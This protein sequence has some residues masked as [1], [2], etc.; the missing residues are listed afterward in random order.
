MALL[1]VVSSGCMV[2]HSRKTYEMV[3]VKIPPDGS[4]EDDFVVQ[5]FS[6]SYSSN[7]FA[8]DVRAPFR[9]DT[10]YHTKKPYRAYGF[11]RVTIASGSFRQDLVVPADRLRVM[12]H[13]VTS[14][15][16]KG[17]YYAEINLPRKFDYVPADKT[18]ILTLEIQG[19]VERGS[20]RR[21]FVWKERYRYEENRVRAWVTFEDLMGI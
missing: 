8:N 19:W 1:A 21:P 9:I 15:V 7:I 5:V 16:G 2:N 11:E 4:F 3:E 13:T 18:E 12:A 6:T 20:G 10:R 17:Q 14:G